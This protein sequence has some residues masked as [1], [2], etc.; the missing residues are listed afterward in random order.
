MDGRQAWVDAR[1]AEVE[2]LYRGDTT[3]HRSCGIALAEA[4]GC[5]TPPYQALRR[6]GITGH[7]PCGAIQAGMLVLGEL[8]G[9]PD[10]T[11]PVTPALRSAAAAYRAAL[12]PQVPGPLE[13]S[14]NDRTADLGPFTG[15]ARHASCTALAGQV[16]AAVAGVLWDLEHPSTR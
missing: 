8:L 2:R 9:D 7:G 13:Q 1:R 3:P 14:C 10:P 16:A 6:G 4:F 12:A 11:G 15:P 5:A